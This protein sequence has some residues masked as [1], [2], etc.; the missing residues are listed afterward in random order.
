MVMV[1]FV[2]FLLAQNPFLEMSIGNRYYAYV[3]TSMSRCKLPLHVTYIPLS[4]SPSSDVI[5]LLSFYLVASPCKWNTPNAP[6]LWYSFY[7]DGLRDFAPDQRHL[8]GNAELYVPPH[9]PAS[10]KMHAPTDTVT[11]F[12]G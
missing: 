6:T 2:T 12:A 11:S 3:L 10:R 5:N 1:A 8:P 9:L 4:N 7:E